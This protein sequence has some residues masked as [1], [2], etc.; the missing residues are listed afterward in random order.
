GAIDLADA[1]ATGLGAWDKF[2]IRYGYSQ[3]APGADER[4][5]LDAIL[6]EARASGLEYISDRDARAAGGAHPQ[7]HLWD[8][9]VDA[10]DELDRVMTV[11]A[12]ALAGFSEKKIRFGAPLATLEEVL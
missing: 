2:A 5:G 11:R 12:A 3:F 6:E 10:A 1:Y 7:A 8:S 9:G 4:A